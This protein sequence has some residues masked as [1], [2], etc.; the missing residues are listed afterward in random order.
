MNPLF[1]EILAALR[2]EGKI[3]F[4]GVSTHA[5]EQH[6]IRAAIES[7]LYDVVLTAYNFKHVHRDEIKKAI[8]EAAAAGLGVVAMK[9]MAGGWMDVARTIPVN[10]KAALKCVL[11]DTNVHTTIRG[12]ITFDQILYNVDY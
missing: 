8:A 11:Q 6:T 9:T 1:L 5:Y 3:R 12:I 10:T 7:K 2:D 4:A